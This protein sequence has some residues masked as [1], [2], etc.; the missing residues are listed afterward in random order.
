MSITGGRERER[1]REE[2]REKEKE[3]P[4]MECSRSRVTLSGFQLL[5]HANWIRRP[6]SCYSPLVLNRQTKHGSS[7]NVES[8]SHEWMQPRLCC[9]L[10]ALPWFIQEILSLS[11]LSLS[12]SLAPA[13]AI[14]VLECDERSMANGD[15]I[16]P[17]Y[18]SPASLASQDGWTTE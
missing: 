8:A 9:V 16:S 18:F 7:R 15:Q 12:L 6:H 1:K 3:R 14:L 5:L 10:L 13:L 11:S 2:E 4:R 17:G